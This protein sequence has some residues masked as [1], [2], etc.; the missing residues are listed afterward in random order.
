M[1]KLTAANLREM[2]ATVPYDAE[3]WVYGSVPGDD[4]YAPAAWAHF[5]PLSGNGEATALNVGLYTENSAPVPVIRWVVAIGDAECEP[6]VVIDAL[7][8]RPA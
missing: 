3:V 6:T 2:L 1:P 8:D 4:G 7:L 5:L